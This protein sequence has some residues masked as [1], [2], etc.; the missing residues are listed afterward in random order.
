M[1]PVIKNSIRLLL[2]RK[3]TLFVLVIMPVIVFSLGLFSGGN[4]DGFRL[5]AGIADMDETPLS[6]A[7]AASFAKEV[8][9]LDAVSPD[10]M[11]QK[12]ADGVLDA[13]LVIGKGYESALLT[14]K[15]PALTLRSLKGQ[16]VV[17]ALGAWL[18]LYVSD[19]LRLR[20]LEK[21][22]DAAQLTAA[23]KRLDELALP[24][25]QQPLSPHKEN[26]GLSTAAGFLLYLIS[27]NMLQVSSL[28]LREK[29][30]G[31]LSRVLQSPVKRLSYIGAN[32]LTGL[33]FLMTNLLTLHL[34]TALVFRISV[35]PLMYALWAFYGLIWVLAGIFLAFTV[36]SSQ[37]YN[38]V[39]PIVTTIFAM[40]G[41][42]YWPLWLMPPFMQKLAMITPQYWANT[43]G[44]LIQKGHSLFASG[45]EIAVLAGFLLLFLALCLFALRRKKS[46]ELFI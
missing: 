27:M 14:G 13:V 7:L 35:P 20:T 32:F 44:T 45:T 40:L 29:Q 2:A 34:L 38:A 42:C 43:A 18:N 9:R 25:S 46:A 21:T 23:E 31:T 19:L 41:G 28:L 11:D 30:W 3:A 5:H 22:A 15:S 12:L 37:V 6:R 8:Y 39:T 1:L 36:R 17:G 16:E 10:D 4:S 24:F 26:R 33:F